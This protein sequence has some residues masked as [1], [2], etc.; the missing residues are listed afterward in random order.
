MS[1]SNYH[2]CFKMWW[3]DKI[4]FGQKAKCSA[5]RKDTDVCSIA[6]VDGCRPDITSGVATQ[7]TH[8]LRCL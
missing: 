8:S 7:C 1:F 6:N 5:R 2:C 4:V 3:V